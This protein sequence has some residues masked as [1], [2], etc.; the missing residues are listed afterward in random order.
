[1]HIGFTISH[2]WSKGTHC[3]GKFVHIL[4]VLFSLL[5]SILKWEGILPQLS[6]I[7]SSLGEC[8]CSDFCCGLLIHYMLLAKPMQI[9]LTAS[10]D[11]CP[12]SLSLSNR[13]NSIA[14]SVAVQWSKPGALF[15]PLMTCQ[16]YTLM[17]FDFRWLSWASIKDAFLPMEF[18]TNL[19]SL[20]IWK[21]LG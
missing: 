13:W 16:A 4:F 18:I 15:L 5:Q 3:S 6:A 20:V 9:L 17:W 1:M 8:E 21:S 10:F 7:L 12:V 2:S 11:Q 14:C 19:K